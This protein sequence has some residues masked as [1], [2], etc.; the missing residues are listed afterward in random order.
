MAE[1]TA[2]TGI[3]SDRGQPEDG[4]PGDGLDV[5]SSQVRVS[6]TLN[7][8]LYGLSTPVSAS[9]YVHRHH[10]HTT[11]ITLFYEGFWFKLSKCIK[12]T[13]LYVTGLTSI[14]CIQGTKVSHRVLRSTCYFNKPQILTQLRQECLM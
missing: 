10:L 8:T 5:R 9:S 13:F 1:K 6:V 7:V 11:N 4:D 2:K 12:R 3:E 14:S